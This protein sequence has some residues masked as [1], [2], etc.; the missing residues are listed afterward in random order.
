[1]HDQ[2]G[3]LEDAA[4]FGWT[5][6]DLFFCLSGFLI[7]SQLFVQIKAGQTIAFKPFF[8]KRFF[9][10]VPAYLVVV[11]IYFCFPYFREKRGLTDL[12]RFLTFT[13]NFG[14]DLSKT[15]AFTHS[16]SLCVEE[17]FYLALP[18]LLIAAQKLQWL[19]KAAWLLLIIFILGF[20]LRQYSYQ[21]YWEPVS[22]DHRNWAVWYKYVYYPTYNRLDGLMMGVSI[23]AV[24][25]FLPAWWNRFT[26]YHWLFFIAG[27]G[28]LTG[29][30]FV[31]EDQMTWEATVIGFP[32]VSLGY[33][34]L[35]VAAVSPGN[36]LYK[37]NS[38]VTT[39][40]AV[41]SYAV[42]LT[43][44]GAIHITQDLLEDK[45][46]DP[47]WMMVVCVIVSVLFGLILRW[48]VEKPF[49]KLREK[50]LRSN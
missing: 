21:H 27:L 46:I 28:M 43:H 2:P 20:I 9:R 38:T 11:A 37:W 26:K 17:H 47:N 14:L 12:W 8:L 22:N 3:W 32:M 44:K 1:M 7:A 30:W 42:Y 36:F 23:A 15:K 33:A 19:K 29:A 39:F 34:C 45:G 41:L 49:M 4:R 18:I 50:I 5:G 48:V 31:C 40:I 13:Q 16:W 6:V 10:I 24:S 25:Q 35:L